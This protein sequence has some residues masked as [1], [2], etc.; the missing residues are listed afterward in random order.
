MRNDGNGAAP[1]TTLRYYRST[2]AAIMTADTAVGTAAVA[3]LAA[4]GG[5]SE[6]VDLTAPS[7]SG[8]YYYGACVD[9]VAGEADTTD[10]CSTSVQIT[11]AGAPPPPQRRPDLVVA[12]PSTSDRRPIAGGSFTLSATVRNAGAADAPATTLRYYRSTDAAIT[13][14]DTEVGTDAVAS[15]AATATAAES[16]DLTAPADPG[17]YYYG[18]CVDTVADESD[19]TNNCS[20]AL[21]VEVVE[22]PLPPDLVVEH[23]GV[24]PS[25]INAGDRFVITVTVRN[26]GAGD[27]PVSPTLR[28]YYS[29]DDVISPDDR[30]VGTD[31]IGPLAAARS[32]DEALYLN[33]PSAGGTYY[34]GA[35]VGTVPQETSTT[36]NCSSAAALIVEVPPPAPQP[37]PDLMVAAPAVSDGRPAAGASFT[38]SATVRNA[39][40]GA[41]SATILRFYRSTDA[42]ITTTDTQVGT[43]AVTALAAAATAAESVDLTAPADP[44]TY[45]YGA[46]VDAVTDESDTTNNCSTSVQVTVPDAPSDTPPPPRGGNPDLVV[47][48][49]SVSDG[50]PDPGASFTLSTTV[51]NAGD[52][53]ANATTLRYYRSTDAAITTADTGV[54]TD[55]VTALAAA[56]TAAESVNLTA[57]ADPGTYYYGACVDTVAGRVGHLQQLLGGRDGNG[58]DHMP[59]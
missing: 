6:S 8:T 42:A 1:P 37:E 10:N 38:L 24:T 48:T 40:D 32:I 23:A 49:P 2:D 22:R 5:V 31:F 12:P 54:G 52:G 3:A 30:E 43:D 21:Q 35:C 9:A 47:A 58:A 57:P 34:Y 18:A 28:Y 50:R 59:T 26:R 7:N 33:A 36:N 46:C 25:S 39:G 45:Y 29:L 11:V 15:L 19:S 56:A 4:S 20:A 13:T 14:A 27:S 51:R 44:G 16:V 55:A 17:T 41:A 53:A